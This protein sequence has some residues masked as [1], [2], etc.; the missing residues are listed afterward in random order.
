MLVSVLKITEPVSA[1]D[2]IENMFRFYNIMF[3]PA[4]FL[5]LLG[6]RKLKCVKPKRGCVLDICLWYSSE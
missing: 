3:R 1:N 5:F 2:S 4:A 6:G